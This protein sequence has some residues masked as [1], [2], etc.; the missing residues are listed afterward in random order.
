MGCRIA[1]HAAT[2]TGRSRS[3]LARKEFEASYLYAVLLFKSNWGWGA[4]WGTG[5]RSN[6][7]SLVSFHTRYRKRNHMSM[8]NAKQ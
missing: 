2:F 5:R 4:V 6:L 1:G 3:L 8:S 7:V